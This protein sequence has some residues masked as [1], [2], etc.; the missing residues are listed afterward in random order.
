MIYIIF[1]L[2]LIIHFNKIHSLNNKKI[3]IILKIAYKQNKHL[4][5]VFI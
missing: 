2:D 1:L 3:I 4:N 5:K